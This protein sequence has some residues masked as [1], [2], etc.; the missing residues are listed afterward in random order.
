MKTSLRSADAQNDNVA[1][2]VPAARAGAPPPPPYE[3]GARRWLLY[4]PLC[5]VLGHAAALVLVPAVAAL[6]LAWMTL[7]NAAGCV[8]R[9]AWSEL[10]QGLLLC[11]PGK[12]LV[13]LPATVLCAFLARWQ[14]IL[15]E[16]NFFP[17]HH[18]LLFVLPVW[19]SPSAK[20]RAFGGAGDETAARRLLGGAGGETGGTAAATARRR[21]RLGR[22]LR[23]GMDKGRG[24]ESSDEGCLAVVARLLAEGAEPDA[25]G[26][27]GWSALHKMCFYGNVRTVAALLEGGADA[28]MR[29]NFGSAP[30]HKP[31]LHALDPAIAK[32]LLAHGAD[33]NALDN[34]GR[35]PLMTADSEV[36][37]PPPPP[38]PP[39]PQSA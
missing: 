3:P 7:A 8:R 5:W 38:P 2:D 19:R 30:L 6:N 37:P 39:P 24:G 15:A 21:H 33:P 31:P 29:R 16:F 12:A 25:V 10:L 27:E 36:S 13:W 35:T 17:W 14:S 4:H 1:V 32:L 9:G 26:P 34:G 28:N 18:E 20:L 23:R 22:Q 11:A